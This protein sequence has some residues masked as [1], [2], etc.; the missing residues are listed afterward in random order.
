MKEK[1]GETEMHKIETLLERTLTEHFDR[2][3]TLINNH[4]R[5][6]AK[7]PDARHPQSKSRS[8]SPA[9]KLAPE[10]IPIPRTNNI[11]ISS[12][13]L[14]L[15]LSPPKKPPGGAGI[16]HELRSRKNSNTMKPPI[17]PYALKPTT[18]Q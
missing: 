18:P 5:G 3:V 14:F 11:P 8:P 6:G 9:R 4:D 13:N 2:M 16:T 17:V 12:P 7:L 15:P 10:P 1:E